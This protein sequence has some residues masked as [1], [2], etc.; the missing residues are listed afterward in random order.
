MCSYWQF[1]ST[2]HFGIWPQPHSPLPLVIRRILNCPILRFSKTSP[3]SSCFGIKH[4]IVQSF[5]LICIH[6]ILLH[7]IQTFTF[8][9]I[10]TKIIHALFHGIVNSLHSLDLLGILPSLQLG[11]LLGDIHII[12]GSNICILNKNFD[13]KSYKNITMLFISWE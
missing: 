6:L 5:C 11:L 3:F 7:L 13:S 2:C 10:S 4:L 12:N 8:F 1:V 9:Q